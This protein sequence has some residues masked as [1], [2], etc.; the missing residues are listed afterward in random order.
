LILPALVS[1]SIANATSLAP[2]SMVPWEQKSTEQPRAI[3]TTSESLVAS[4][5][6]NLRNQPKA[7]IKFVKEAKLVNDNTDFLL[8]L[9]ST[10]YSINSTDVI[11]TLA[12]NRERIDPQQFRLGCES[13]DSPVLHAKIETLLSNVYRQDVLI[14]HFLRRMNDKSESYNKLQLIILEMALYNI[15]PH[16]TIN[17]IDS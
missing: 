11:A 13:G 14:D 7:E 9:N 3:G 4:I 12:A 1:E 5:L 6:S 2:V 15:K 10:L 8:N 17:Q 16:H